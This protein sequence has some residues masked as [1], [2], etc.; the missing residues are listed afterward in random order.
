MLMT[1][2]DHL[3]I[4]A[5]VIQGHLSLVILVECTQ[6]IVTSKTIGGIFENK[7][8]ENKSKFLQSEA[9]FTY[10][11]FFLIL[12]GNSA[13]VISYQNAVQHYCLH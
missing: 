7:I 1:M 11:F 9:I 4:S 10:T 2:M 13:A 8:E 6:L 3:T 5:Q 12:G